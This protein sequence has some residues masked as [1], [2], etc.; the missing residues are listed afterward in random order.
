MHT[1]LHLC[2]VDYFLEA[3]QVFCCHLLHAIL[4]LEYL[5]LGLDC[6]VKEILKVRLKLLHDLSLL[7][8]HMITL[9]LLLLQHGVLHIS[10]CLVQL[11]L[12]LESVR[13][14]VD[15]FKVLLDHVVY[16]SGLAPLIQRVKNRLRD[17][18]VLLLLLLNDLVGHTVEWLHLLIKKQIFNLP[19]QYLFSCNAGRSLV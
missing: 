16:G 13:F 5:L 11:K 15:G 1:Q 19:L 9:H 10:V 7:L 4:L 8:Q 14:E 3:V 12:E 17:S 18:L 6:L 2:L